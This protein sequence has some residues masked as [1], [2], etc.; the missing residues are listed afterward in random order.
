MLDIE[1]E[2]DRKLRALY[3]HIETQDPPASL[4]PI[5]TPAFRSGRKVLGRLVGVA[6]IA[7]IAG[8]ALF[9]AEL[10]AHRLSTPPT[11]ITHPVS[12]PSPAASPSPVWSPS[13]LP[14][15]NPQ[16]ALPSLPNPTLLPVTVRV[17]VPETQG[18]GDAS[19][20]IVPEG[21]L[22]IQY[23]CVSGGGGV[24]VVLPTNPPTLGPEVRPR[25]SPSAAAATV[26]GT[27]LPEYPNEVLKV[28]TLG[29]PL[30]LSISAGSSTTWE[31]FI[32]ESAP[33][34]PPSVVSQGWIAVS[35]NPSY[36]GAGENG[37]IYLLS[38]GAAPRRIIGS[39]GDGIA[40][41]CP[42]FSP[43]GQRLAYGEAHASGTVTTYRG[44]WPVSDRAV[45][46]VELNDPSQ[47][48]MRVTLPAD[49][50]EIMCPK[51][52]PDGTHAAFRVG[53]GLW[54]ANTTSG[55]T[56]VFQVGL[57]PW[58]Q[59]GFAW[60]RDGSRIAV[61]EPGQIR[62]VPIDGSASAVIP[63][64]GDTP[65]SIGWTANDDAIVYASTD[66]PGDALAV[67][68]V[69]ADGTNDTQLAHSGG[70]YGGGAAVSPDGTRV[71]YIDGVHVLTMDTRGGKVVAVSVPPNFLVGGLLWS[72]DGKRLLLSSINGVVSVA[73]APG[74]APIVY[75]TALYPGGG[76]D[77][78]WSWPEVTWQPV[79]GPT[80]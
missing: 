17:L 5:M 64:K 14:S 39:D 34:V 10:H 50:G 23:A 28:G 69:D 30:T 54:V 72:P 41:A 58:G 24:V 66:A 70:A 67:N 42:T 48:L 62:V 49:P 77:L 65:G 37:D 12:P 56:T 4:A 1:P 20:T 29:K 25:C 59:Q 75:A 78:E 38:E 8:I 18:V 74:S 3:D 26:V 21:E 71:A 47:P 9:A 60:S 11:P 2:L 36:N 32:A 35:A 33:P 43:D 40:Q 44:V 31:I 76:L 53:T 52:S 15:P 19:V 51:W 7:A 45:V 6:A 61:A 79:T 80:R 68:R 22:F 55:K 73:L 27:A 63:V 16:L 13:P 46:V 57:T